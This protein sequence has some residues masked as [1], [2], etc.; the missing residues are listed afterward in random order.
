MSTRPP[1]L[2]PCADTAAW[3]EFD[4]ARGF[5]TEPPRLDFIW[6]G[7]LAGTVGA[8]IAPGAT[9]KSFWALE[10][11][12][13]IACSV[14]GGDVVGLEPAHTGRVVFFAGEDQDQP[15]RHGPAVMG[16]RAQGRS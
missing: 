13:A 4:I 15:G 2:S 9:G 5:E 7:F 12:M 10:G 1:V 16:A 11:A 3:R 8:L 14:A 6:S